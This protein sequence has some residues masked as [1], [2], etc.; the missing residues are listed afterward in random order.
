[1]SSK[2]YTCDSVAETITL[3]KTIG[4]NLSGGEVFELKSD[5]GGGKTTFVN[6]LV[7][8]FG[9]SDPVAS[10]SFTISYVYGR[11]DGKQ[12]HHFDFYRLND[13]G[14]VGNE[15]AEV[16]QNKDTVVAVEW[17]DIVHDILPKERIIANISVA[18]DETRKF[19]F[20]YPEKFSY[21]FNK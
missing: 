13:A 9:S 5:L 4:T 3:G 7:Q 10:P 17:G 16:E 19:N 11:P 14:I 18:D 6:G 2:T 12:F 20:E 8:G 21:L 15:L 1:M